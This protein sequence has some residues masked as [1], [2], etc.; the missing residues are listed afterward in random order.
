MSDSWLDD[1]EEL[2]EADK[3][4]QMEPQELNLSVLKKPAAADPGIQV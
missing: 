2:Y 4:N 3:K 1:L